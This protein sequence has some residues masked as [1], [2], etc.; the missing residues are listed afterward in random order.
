MFL[1]LALLHVLG[2]AV[3]WF[4]KVGDRLG[5]KI[6]DRAGLPRLYEFIIK[7]A[8]ADICRTLKTISEPVHQ[9]VLIHCSHGKDRLWRIL[10]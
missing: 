2:K 7:H 8:G 1:V 3:P 4:K 9:P 10:Q 6:I 5:G